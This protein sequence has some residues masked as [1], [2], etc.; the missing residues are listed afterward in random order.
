M[1]PVTPR[2][3]GYSGKD[4]RR[5]QKAAEHNEMAQRVADHI[6]ALVANN[7]KETQQYM[8]WVIAH[9]LG[10]TEDQVRAVVAYGGHNGITFKV[11]EEDR[12]ALARY[13]RG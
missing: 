2:L 13:K 9:D 5:R 7:P 8:Y 11:T 4:Q 3:D 12:R 10:L 6:N 1:L